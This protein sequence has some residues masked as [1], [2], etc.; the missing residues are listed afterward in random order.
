MKKWI[1][2]KKTLNESAIVFRHYIIE[3]ESPDTGKVGKFDVLKCSNWVNVMAYDKENNLVMVKQYRHGNDDITLEIPGGAIDPGEEPL[4]A[5]KREL[6]EE[7]GYTSSQ[8]SLLGKV[9][10]NP[11][12]MDNE[13]FTYL[14][15]NCEKTH[16]QSLDP[17]E[18]VD[19][20]LIKRENLRMMVAK[21][22][23]NHS[24]VLSAFYLDEINQ[25]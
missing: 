7:T 25:F 24:I 20:E 6:R 23:I 11:A 9:H 12:F 18:E 13:C 4:I 16:E 5:A 17:L 22:E 2:N 8:W 21:G 1:T 15:L 14:A 10:P 3:R 19:V